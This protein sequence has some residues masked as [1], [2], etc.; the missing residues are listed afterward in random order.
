MS[1][2]VIVPSGVKG[3]LP[4]CCTIESRLW[5]HVIMCVTAIISTS[6]YYYDVFISPVTNSMSAKRLLVCLFAAIKN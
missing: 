5:S 4:S 3:E 2:E 1:L 6:R